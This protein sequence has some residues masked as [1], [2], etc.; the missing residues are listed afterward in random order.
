MLK[1]KNINKFYHDGVKLIQV[2]KDVNMEIEKGEFVSVKGPSGAGKSTLLH[3]IGGL[4]NPSKG[5]VILNNHSIY[6][7]QNSKRAAL[8]NNTFGFVFQFFHLLPEFNILENVIF[9]GLI[10]GKFKKRYLVKKGKSLLKSVG[11]EKRIHYYPNKLSGGEKQRVAIARAIVLEPEILLC[12]EP[13]GN[14]DSKITHQICEL[15]I[16]LHKSKK[17][18]IILVSHQEDIASKANKRYFITD[19]KLNRSD[20]R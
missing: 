17:Q 10:S 5:E 3:V 6:K 7:L 19:G 11:L 1:L 4:D 15:L 12:D 13:T 2:L 18:T 8:R 9:P 16:D 14:L 20:N